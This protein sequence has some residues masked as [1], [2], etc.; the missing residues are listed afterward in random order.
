[1]ILFLCDFDSWQL[2]TR[3]Q[4]FINNMTYGMSEKGKPAQQKPQLDMFLLKSN[5]QKLLRRSWYKLHEGE[6]RGCTHTVYKWMCC[7][8][9]KES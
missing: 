9:Y 4:K 1:M 2:K 7:E 6:G 3:K 5:E 8:G